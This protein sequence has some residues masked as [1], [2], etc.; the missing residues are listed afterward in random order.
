MKA[1]P[2]QTILAKKRLKTFHP[3]SEKAVLFDTTEKNDFWFSIVRKCWIE[4]KAKKPRS[5]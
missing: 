2:M 5:P 3:F 4:R 1:T